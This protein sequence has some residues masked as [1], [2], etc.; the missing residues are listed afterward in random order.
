MSIHVQSYVWKNSAQKGSSLL[1]LL[2][3]ADCANEDGNNIYPSVKSMAKM[4]RMSERNCQY[5][6]RQL[7]ECGEVIKH[8]SSGPRGTTMFSIPMTGAKFAPP[9][10]L[11]DEASFAGG[12]KPIA[13]KPLYEPSKIVTGSRPTKIDPELL[14]SPEWVDAANKLGIDYD[15][16]WQFDQF[17]D[18]HINKQDTAVEWKRS[19]QTWCRNAVAWRKRAP[20]NSTVGYQ[21]ADPNDPLKGWQG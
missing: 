6:L 5:V 10:H 19:W 15:V 9:S 16:S 2:Y 3:L 13:P 18:H 21:P 14:L 20:R 11:G 17:M 4:T 8:D 1:L 7:V 12:V